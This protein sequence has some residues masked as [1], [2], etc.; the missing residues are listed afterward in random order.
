MYNKSR[1]TLFTVRSLIVLVSCILFLTKR[2][3]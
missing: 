3:Q 1:L 2:V